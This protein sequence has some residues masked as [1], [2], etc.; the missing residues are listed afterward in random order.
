MSAGP[1]AIP[2]T[3]QGPFETVMALGQH[4]PGRAGHI[5]NRKLKR[6]YCAR[7]SD[8]FQTV[9]RDT[10]AGDLCIDLG[11]NIGAITQQMAAT[12]AEVISFEPDP[13]TF[14]LLRSNTSHLNGVTLSQKA[15]GAKAEQLLLRRAARWD[16][17]DPAKHS[18]ASSIV[19]ADERMSMENAVSVE[20]VDMVAFLTSL[21]R[22]IR[23]LKIDIEG[24]EWDLMDALLEAPVLDRIACIFVET[25]ERVNPAVNIPRFNRLAAR[26]C[27]LERPYINLYWQ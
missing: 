11:A 22:D 13:D 14:E 16:P 7:M 4:L 25:H 1:K 15:A 27:A 23:I 21:D 24:A 10:G 6:R 8:T 26:A 5:C 3:P 12:G 19:R 9:L 2:P 20:V 17:A 18:T